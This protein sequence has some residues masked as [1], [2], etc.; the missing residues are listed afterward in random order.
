MTERVSSLLIGLAIGFVLGYFT[1]T[2]Q[3]IERKV[4]AMDR[5]VKKQ[6]NEEGFMR[7]PL[8]ADAM[9]IVI[10]CVSV[11]ASFQTQK[12]NNDLQETQK[13]QRISTQCTQEYLAKT[14]LAL[15]ERTENT[16]NTSE[17]NVELQKAQ[18][19]FLRL[20]LIDPPLPDERIESGLRTYFESLT[21]FIDAA[22]AGQTKRQMYPYP[23]TEEFEHCTDSKKE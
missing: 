11:F 4:D 18:V 14:I 21:E 6:R 9:M 23:T 1:R 19:A 5:M 10:L 13:A 12:V 20:T 7:F 16:I 8:M 17:K 15:N 3:K 22:A 2:L